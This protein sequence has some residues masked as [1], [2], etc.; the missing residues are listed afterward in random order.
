[1]DP[2]RSGWGELDTKVSVLL[3]NSETITL[4]SKDIR[5][6]HKTGQVDRIPALQG[7]VMALEH[8][9]NGFSVAF[10]QEISPGVLIHHKDIAIAIA[11]TQQGH[12]VVMKAVVQSS[13]PLHGTCLIKGVQHVQ[14]AAEVGKELPRGDVPIAMA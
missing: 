11:T 1:M 6:G 9:L 14:L 4:A 12:G 5:P 2:V 8:S 10:G 3:G 7:N 13:K